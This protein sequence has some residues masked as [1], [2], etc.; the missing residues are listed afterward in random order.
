MRRREFITLVGS[1]VAWP[2]TARAQQPVTPVIGF[3]N[4]ASPKGYAR[5]LAAFLKGLSETGYVDGQNVTIEYRWAEDHDRS[6]S[7]IDSRSSAPAS[8]GNSGD[9]HPSSSGSKSCN[10]YGTDRI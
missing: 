6:T 2:L 7:W 3:V 4:S 8:S 10:H 5:P 1:A 9:D